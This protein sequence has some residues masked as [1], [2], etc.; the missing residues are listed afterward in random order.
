MLRN[1][2]KVNRF[3]EKYNYIFL[4][5]KN[6]NCNGTIVEEK[7][8]EVVQLTGDQRLN[9]AKFLQE[10]GIAKGENIKVHGA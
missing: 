7:E 6:L 3:N 4:K 8:A 1:W 2:K 9:I 10:E 5:I